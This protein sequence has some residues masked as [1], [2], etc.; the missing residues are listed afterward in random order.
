M[1]EYD[2]ATI[3]SPNPLARYAH[4]TRVR[5]SL[6]L[7]RG[8]L[9][10]GRVLDYGCGSGVLIASLESERP[11][12]AVGYE[13]FMAERCQAG[14]PIFATM[15]EVRGQGPFGTVTLFETIEHLSDAEL[16]AFLA[17]CDA[18]LGPEGAIVVSAPIE[19]GPALFLKECNRFLLRLKPSEHY[20]IEFLK[21]SLLGIPARRATEL[22]SSHRGFD[23]RRAIQ[24]M[25]QKGWES[26]ILAY[27]PLPIGT[28]YG[29]S[30]VYFEV[31]RAG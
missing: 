26:K 9:D 18:V 2:A 3:N 23:F 20:P 28:W 31:R 6:E 24:S 25:R 29:N 15:D 19:V 1:S 27:G 8:R 7:V 4:R 30:Q 5:R 10:A 11:G 22:K 14:L 17:D 12:S 21:A 16:D 13:P